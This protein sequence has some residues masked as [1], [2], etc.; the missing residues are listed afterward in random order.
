M[1]VQGK[2]WNDTPGCLMWGEL[3]LTAFKVSHLS[4]IDLTFYQEKFFP[5]DKVLLVLDNCGPHK[6][7]VVE[8]AF[9]DA[10][11]TTIFFPPNMTHILQSWISLLTLLSNPL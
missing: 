10:G 11:W 6:V 4:S 9:I 2:A 3:Q 7:D 1:N 5:N 8:R